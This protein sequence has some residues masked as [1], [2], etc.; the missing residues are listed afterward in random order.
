MSLIETANN[1]YGSY[2]ILF[3]Q[4]WNMRVPITCAVAIF[5]RLP[6]KI[7]NIDSLLVFFCLM[8]FFA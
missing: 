2:Y 6:V 7:N 8:T 4:R 3:L 5:E 1:N